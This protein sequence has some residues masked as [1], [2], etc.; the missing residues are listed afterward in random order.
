M[1]VKAKRTGTPG[2][3]NLKDAIMAKASE[4]WDAHAE[5]VLRIIKDSEDHKVTVG[6]SSDID[7]SESAPSIT[8]KIRFSETF[9][10][11]RKVQL[12]DPNQG[13]FK[14][15][16]AAAEEQPKQKKKGRNQSAIA[17]ATE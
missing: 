16:V 7:C 9:T 6:F 8:I 10:D 4:L 15:V 11:T 1:A 14:D 3:G 12:D 17:E 2:G 13:T 5:E